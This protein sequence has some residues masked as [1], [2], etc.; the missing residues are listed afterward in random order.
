MW[1]PRPALPLNDLKE[2]LSLYKQILKPLLTDLEYTQA[3]RKINA[4]ENGQGLELHKRLLEY[5][6]DIDTRETAMNKTQHSIGNWLD[7]NWLDIGYHQWRV[8]LVVNSNWWILLKPASHPRHGPIGRA[9]LFTCAILHYKVQV[10]QEQIPQEKDLCM[11]QYKRLFAHRFPNFNQDSIKLMT[12]DYIIVMIHNQCFKVTVMNNN[13]IISPSQLYMLFTK[14][15]AIMS[16]IQCSPAIPLL[17]TLNRDQW[18]TC[19][20]H[21][22]AIH[23][24]NKSSL[25]IIENALFCVCFD[26]LMCDGFDQ[27]LNVIAHGLDGHNR[28]FDK[29]FNVIVMKDGQIGINGE[30]SPLDA[31]IPSYM[32]HACYLKESQ[33][34]WE[35]GCSTSDPVH[36]PFVIDQTISSY[37]QLA[38][39]ETTLLINSSDCGVAHFKAYGKSFMKKANMS[40]DTFIQLS[41]QW[42][43]YRLHQ[44]ITSTYETASTRSFYKGRT[45][46]CRTTSQESVQWVKYMQQSHVIQNNLD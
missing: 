2:T 29:S 21:L 1:K 17:T 9:S 20:Q 6:Q 41:F 37:I 34:E 5:K 10:D 30:H 38:Q 11:E 31:L 39:K 27:Q 12:S 13:E 33:L 35:Q 42:T 28:W 4:F 23:P 18:A 43:W 7:K 26:D 22:Q 25:S 15:Y 24:D 45:E 32:F 19:Y 16:S 8:S 3:I 46:T 44:S 14:C 36:L 40:P